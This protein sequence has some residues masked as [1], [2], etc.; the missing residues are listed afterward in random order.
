MTLTAA[1]QLLALTLCALP[2]NAQEVPAATLSRKDIED[3]VARA[4][5]NGK[6][7][8][9]A[10]MRP[11]RINVSGTGFVVQLEGP[12]NRIDRLARQQLK[13]YLPFTADSVPEKYLTAVVS[14]VAAPL[15]QVTS[16]GFSGE[17]VT[18]PATHAVIAVMSD[19]VERIIQPLSTETFDVAVTGM[20]QENREPPK[21]FTSK[22]I[23]ATF[24]L[25]ALPATKFEIR[26]VTESKEFKYEVEGNK[27][28][29]VR[30]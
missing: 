23:R 18:P 4:K 10:E 22:G 21:A 16:S 7:D 8:Q 29:L 1:L 5:A 2:I 14:I 6:P 26:I 13:K 17:M 30:D 25:D 19:G 9:L 27:R 12:L 20:K 28:A 15:G 3:V 11:S 24:P